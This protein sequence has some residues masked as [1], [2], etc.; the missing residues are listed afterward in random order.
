[1]AENVTYQKRTGNE[2]EDFA[3]QF[4]RLHGYQILDR[5]YHSR[6]GEVDIVAAHDQCVVFVE[7]KTRTSARFGLPE[8]SVT[9]KKL[10]KINNTGLLWLQDHPDS[11][12]DW[13]VDV[14]AI[15]MDKNHQMIDIQHFVDID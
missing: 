4:L 13:R 10:E 12:D 14:I 8:T 3:A 7:V 5:N 1:M 15:L 6:Y 2:G 11:P 9:P